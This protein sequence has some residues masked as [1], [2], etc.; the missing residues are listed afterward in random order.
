MDSWYANKVLHFSNQAWTTK[1]KCRKAA[2]KKL[3]RY[4]GLAQT[5]ELSS[6]PN[7]ALDPGDVV[8]LRF[9]SGQRETHEITG[10]QLSLGPAGPMKLATRL[11]RVTED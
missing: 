9:Y 6:V 4:A 7:P 3:S 10:I 1:E 11:K 8:S 5:V 2:S